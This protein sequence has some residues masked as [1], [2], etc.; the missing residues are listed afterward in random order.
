MYI[1]WNEIIFS[2]TDD[3]DKKIMKIMK[4][5]I[6]MTTLA[7]AGEKVSMSL[8]TLREKYSVT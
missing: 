2:N 8:I 5:M 4:R 3:D 7:K 6:M 1:V